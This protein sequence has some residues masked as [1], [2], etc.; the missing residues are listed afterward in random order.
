MKKLSKRLLSILLSVLMVLTV[1]PFGAFTAHAATLAQAKAAFINKINDMTTK[2]ADD[3]YPVYT[4]LVPAYTAY[5]D[6]CKDGAG[7]TEADALQ[8][9]VDNMTLFDPTTNEGNKTV[10]I[11]GTEATGYYS[12]VLYSPDPGTIQYKD[13]SHGYLSWSNGILK[14]SGDWYVYQRGG[15]LLYTGETPAQ[16]PVVFADKE[17]EGKYAFRFGYVR[18]SGGRLKDVWYGKATTGST[19]SNSEEYDI[20]WSTDT[21]ETVPV[22]IDSGTYYD[23]ENKHGGNS[24]YWNFKNSLVFSLN[25]N[26]LY[27]KFSKFEWNID[28][29]WANLVT[30]AKHNAEGDTAINTKEPVYVINYK[31]LLDAMQ[32]SIEKNKDTYL[33]MTDEGAISGGTGSIFS[34][35][36][37]ATS[38]NLNDEYYHYSTDLETGFQNAYTDLNRAIENLSNA[39][40]A[41]GSINTID[42]MVTLYEK[43]MSSNPFR[44]DLA[45][46]YKLYLKAKECFDAYVFGQVRDDEF[47]EVLK[48]TASKF[49]KAV[50]ESVP[51]ADVDMTGHYT[52]GEGVKYFTGDSSSGDGAYTYYNTPQYAG[53]HKEGQNNI[54]NTPVANLLYY[55]QA[56]NTPMANSGATTSSNYVAVRMYHSN[57]IVLLY[58]GITTPKFPVVA[59]FANNGSSFL[60]AYGWVQNVY[61]T[62][63]NATAFSKATVMNDNSASFRI[64]QQSA[65]TGSNWS[66]S[67]NNRVWVGR[68]SNKTSNVSP[69]GF[70]LL[71]TKSTSGWVNSSDPVRGDK[72]LGGNNGTGALWIDRL[73]GRFGTGAAASVDYA[74]TAFTTNPSQYLDAYDHLNWNVQM[75]WGGSMSSSTYYGGVLS[76][77]TSINVINITPL[78]EKRA[79]LLANENVEQVLRHMFLYDKDSVDMIAF[80]QKI[81][82][83]GSF[84]PNDE[85]YHYETTTGG[86][87]GNSPNVGV[88]D[89][90]ED[91]K[92]AISTFDG[93]TAAVDA[94]EGHSVSGKTVAGDGK[95]E[96]P[97]A[98]EQG[99]DSSSVNHFAPSTNDWYGD[100]RVALLNPQSP[101]ECT[102]DDAWAAYEAVLNSTRA[103]IRATAMASSDYYAEKPVDGS[104][105]TVHDYANDLN[106]ATE[107]FKNS[108]SKHTYLYGEEDEDQLADWEC[109]YG[110]SHNHSSSDMSAYNELEI[111]YKTIDLDAYKTAAKESMKT[112]YD[113]DF[114]DVKT[115]PT[116]K[117]QAPQNYVDSAVVNLLTAINEAEGTDG[118]NLNYYNV[119]FNVVID[120]GTPVSVLTDQ[121]MAYGSTTN[122]VATDAAGFP[123][124]ATCYKWT[125]KIGENDEQTIY[126]NSNSLTNFVQANTTVT[127]Y[128]NS[129]TPEE[130][131]NVQIYGPTKLKLYDINI[132]KD[133]VV[134]FG[135]VAA[136]GTLTVTVDGHDYTVTSSTAYA[137]TG[138][139]IGVEQNEEVYEGTSGNGLESYTVEAL[140]AKRGLTYLKIYPHIEQ[141]ITD[142]YVVSYSGD[143]PATI[144]VNGTD[145][146]LG[147]VDTTLNGNTITMHNAVDGIQYDDKVTITYT[148]NDSKGT[149][150]GIAINVSE[151]TGA[152]VPRYVPI[153]Y[154]TS[155][156]FRANSIMNVYP[157]YQTKVTVG[158]STANVYT[159]EDGRNNGAGTKI[160]NPTDRYYLNRH[161]PFVVDLFDTT[162]VSGKYVFRVMF[163][164]N[165]PDD[166]VIT[167]HGYNFLRLNSAQLVSD[168]SAG[169]NDL[170]AGKSWEIGGNTYAV[171]Q[172]PASKT[173]DPVSHQFSFSTTVP[174]EG[175]YAYQASR[176]YVKFTYDFE[177]TVVDANEQAT[178][179]SAEL[180]AISYGRADFYIHN[181]E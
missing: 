88:D 29:F 153:S 100:L 69:T 22:T 171:T 3:Q 44:T 50:T 91:L 71:W 109:I 158:D 85:K 75:S 1:M 180:E 146:T 164:Q 67:N 79:L 95:V 63:E 127:A 150:Y 99:T 116:A 126:H 58:D 9:A 42:K 179:Y 10:S 83:V 26:T 13:M 62:D 112:A 35:F 107:D 70:E 74:G 8:A 4:N 24:Y 104:N 144:N 57:N 130:K 16:L 90:V 48:D 133:A 177:Q 178:D 175:T 12:N 140:R 145:Q 165:L 124:G 98:T 46:T 52:P 78:L 154:G 21:S 170:V 122:F 73:G 86:T 114:L 176:G 49:E 28:A 55:A 94:S 155:F 151:M 18:E 19:S 38:L 80:L 162:N 66:S 59:T 118:A 163:T 53:S 172:K 157:I 72:D 15:V 115:E 148:P 32:A 129:P 92:T 41:E 147:D 111:A 56:S 149:F 166:V 20:A 84:D 51:I 81:D 169:E 134:N 141:R 5:V 135:T 161:L 117:G 2:G 136:D 31:M 113:G 174:P 123:T 45:E 47:I 156:Y 30:G 82:G 25:D 173:Y 39:S 36:D 54:T 11:N 27:K 7:Q 65:F 43:N 160:T 152:P 131:V 61:P 159:V 76:T 110:T 77:D 89:C 139:T 23:A 103:A 40:S 125:V 97:D 60:D 68:S 64:T 142:G 181:A 119:N 128:V 6:A 105:K 106:A 33:D 108:G 87:H 138:W 17:N 37:T 132:D 120:N 101:D 102:D 14:Y 96:V 121:P 93:V 34:A 143:T 137:V 168:I 167:E